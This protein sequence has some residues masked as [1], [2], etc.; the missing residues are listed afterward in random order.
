MNVRL[1]FLPFL[2]P[3]AALADG[4]ADNLVDNVR[5]QPPPGVVIP[6][7]ARKSLTQGAAMLAAGDRPA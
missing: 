6:D 2:L 4:A 5:R 7:D 3:L 1:I